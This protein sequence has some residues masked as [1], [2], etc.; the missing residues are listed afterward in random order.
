MGS[1]MDN[2]LDN[3]ASTPTAESVLEAMLP[4]LRA[5]HGN[6][7]SLHGRGRAAKDALETARARVAELL[8]LASPERV[9]F[10]S[11]GTEGNRTV[12][13]S[14]AAGERR[15]VLLSAV[16]HPSVLEG[17][18][19]LERSGFEIEHLPVDGEGRPRMAEWLARLDSGVALVSAQWVNN[20]TGVRTPDEVLGALGD[21]ARAVGASFHVDAVQ[22]VGR[23]PIELEG[24]PIDWLTLSAHKIHGPQGVGAL[25][26]PAGAAPTPLIPGGEQESAWRGGTQN[27]PGIV[28]L[29]VAA[30]QARA[31][32]VEDP[33]RLGIRGLRDELEGGLLSAIP[34]VRVAGGGAPRVGNTTCLVL[35]DIEGEALVRRLSHR[36]LA[37]SSGSACGSGRSEPSHVLLAQGFD[38]RGAASSLRLSLSRETRR[39]QIREA[40]ERIP[41]EVASLRALLPDSPGT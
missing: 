12:F 34:D 23:W 21:A 10:T 30:K 26:V 6:P 7:S 41:A 2:Y 18:R 5:S 40:L 32:L 33:G 31:S 25:V 14:C 22:A 3:N 29:G 17:A 24:L 8:G 13:G 20:E 16:E 28:G 11:G 27:L 15:K 35:G 19:T 37:A 39:S 36:G 9:V 1:P 38:R 4:W